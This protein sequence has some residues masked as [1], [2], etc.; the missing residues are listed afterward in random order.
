MSSPRGIRTARAQQQDG[1]WQRD[2]ALRAGVEGAIRQATHTTGLR[3][4]RYRGLVKTHLDHTTSAT[5]LNLS[6]PGGTAT[7]ST[8]PTTA[9]SPNSNSASPH[10]GWD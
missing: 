10:D 1:T 4:A 6:T 5:A 9:T 8:A 3:R 2:Y 7:P